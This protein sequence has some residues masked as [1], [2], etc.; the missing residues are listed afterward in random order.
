[1]AEEPP[2]GPI[3]DDVRAEPLALGQGIRVA[4]TGL[5]VNAI[6]VV[7]KFL[8]GVLGNSYALIADAV[9][10]TGDL[11][12]SLI[13]WGGLRIASR[14]PD[15]EF[16]YGYGRAESLAA[17]L[18]ALML[19][20]A[21]VGIAIESVREIRTPHHLPAP[22]TLLVLV[23]V[24]AIKG[25]MVSRVSRVNATIGSQALAADAWHHLSD[26]LTSLAA[27]VGISIAVLGGP[28][29][30]A[31]DDWAALLASGIILTNGLLLAR[32]AVW[33]LMDRRPDPHI[34]ERIRNTT[35]RVPRVRGVEKLV[36]RK[37][38]PAL[39]VEIHVQADPAMR[40]DEAH[41]VS[42]AVKGTIKAAMPEV[43][44][45]IVHMEPDPE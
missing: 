17:A 6:L 4:Q 31:A 12:A 26:G 28:G 37:M 38:G 42:G 39:H 18:V 23:V 32:P 43:Q 15:E 25:Y 36:A 2:G 20:G 3:T 33:D 10:S 22:W 44:W 14:D 29:W 21:A 45:V 27:L 34:A 8:A 9:E 11:F 19:V 16:P 30:E 7:V 1:M 5:L 13:V 40:L 35:L 24:M 41:Q